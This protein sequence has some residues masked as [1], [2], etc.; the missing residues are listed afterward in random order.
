[1][2]YACLCNQVTDREVIEAIESGAR[3]VDSVMAH[4]RAGGDCGTCHPTIEDLID[5][6]TGSAVAIRVL[7][8]TAA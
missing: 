4:C 6:S 3:C 2:A 7:Q 8:A 5:E 1:V